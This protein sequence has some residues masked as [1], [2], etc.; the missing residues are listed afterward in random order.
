MPLPSC[1]ERLVANG[2]D[3]DNEMMALLGRVAGPSKSVSQETLGRWQLVSL[4]AANQKLRFRRKS[5]KHCS[6]SCRACNDGMASSAVLDRAH[7]RLREADADEG[8]RGQQGTA[9][10]RAPTV[11]QPG[12]TTARR[13]VYHALQQ[14]RRRCQRGT[15]VPLRW[16]AAPSA[17][18]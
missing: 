5:F 12:P 17:C 13:G 7:G 3:G 8:S 14:A 6:G 9:G 18:G 2:N 11:A 16:R 4:S 1:C 10:A 15:Y